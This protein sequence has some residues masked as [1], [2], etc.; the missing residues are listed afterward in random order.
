M[1][2]VTDHIQHGHSSSATYARIVALVP[3]SLP[4]PDAPSPPVPVPVHVTENP[5]DVSPL[6]NSQPAHQ[7]ETVTECVR[8]PETLATASDVFASGI[9]ISHP[10][11]ETS[12]SAPPLSYTFPPAAVILQHNADLPTHSGTSNLPSLAPSNLVPDNIL[13]T[14]PPLSSHLP[15]TRSDFL[16][17]CPE[18]H[19]SRIVTTSP[20]A[21]PAPTSSPEPGAT[22]ERDGSPKPELRKGMAALD[23][24]S[25]NHSI[26]ANSVA[27][28]DISPQF[29]SP[30]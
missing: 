17:S 27:T 1:C 22:A 14:C 25:V 19:C 11:P 4:S 18:S 9:T 23:P 13:P 26:R 20:G 6:D 8:I 28:L 30:P 15:T 7:T 5:M 2:D 10:T 16:P 24:P 29:P 12:T 3:S 21:S